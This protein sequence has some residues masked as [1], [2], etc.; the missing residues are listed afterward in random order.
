MQL[1]LIMGGTVLVLLFLIFFYC[2]LG[3]THLCLVDPGVVLPGPSLLFD[4]VV[5]G[6]SRLLSLLPSHRSWSGVQDFFN[7][8]FLLIVNEIRWGRR[9][10]FLIREHR[11]YI[12]CK[13]LLIEAWMDFPVGR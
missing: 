7:L 3:I 9:R 6:L 13:E 2:F 11:W 5:N 10:L 8:E 4:E 1:S 12:G